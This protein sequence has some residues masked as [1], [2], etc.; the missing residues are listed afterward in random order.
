MPVSRFLPGIAA[1]LAIAFAWIAPLGEA[2]D[3]LAHIRYA[4]SLARGRLPEI[5]PPGSEGYEAHQPPLGYLL[6]ALV[7]AASGGL[8]LHPTSDPGL[9]FHRAGSRASRVQFATPRDALVLH[10]ARST[11]AIWIALATAA[12]IALVG[13]RRVAAAFFLAPQLLFVGGT[14]GND[15]PLV[16]GVTAALLLLVRVS[17]TGDRAALAG[18]LVAACCFVKASAFLL[19][20]PLAVAVWRT[21]RWRARALLLGAS[22]AGI[23]AWCGL[24]LVRFGSLLPQVPTAHRVASLSE[25]VAEP[26]W[27]GALFVSFWAKFGWANTP[28][29]W[30]F[31][32]WFAL[33][34]LAALA[35]GVAMRPRARSILVAAVLANVA[36]LLVYFTT[37]DLQAQGRYLLPSL[38]ALA[39]FAARSPLA[40][41]G[42]SLPI[43]AALVA[44]AAL[45]TLRLAY[46]P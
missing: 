41:L 28:M 21:P 2:P 13:E 19:L 31:Y 7:V 44:G 46:S 14:L 10:L 20:A 24:Q 17:E 38:G 34:T 42:R 8:E 25:L 23:A 3:E 29:A 30:P 22:M 36:L 12:G 6:P 4:E 1:L 35:G 32:V 40:R 45:L 39:A 16:A 18:L 15:A 11:Q 9:D 43:V 33:L 37:V 27:I 26:R 5:S